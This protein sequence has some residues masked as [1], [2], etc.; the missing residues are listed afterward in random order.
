[1]EYIMLTIG[2]VCGLSAKYVCKF[3]LALFTHNEV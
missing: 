3:Y 2:F 1:M